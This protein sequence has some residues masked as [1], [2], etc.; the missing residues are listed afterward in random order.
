LLFKALRVNVK[1]LILGDVVLLCISNQSNVVLLSD[2]HNYM[3]SIFGFYLILLHVS[4][5]HDSHPRVGYRY[6]FRVS[7][8]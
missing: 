1:C 3:S 7:V 5:A 6:Y 4:A 2:K 8:I